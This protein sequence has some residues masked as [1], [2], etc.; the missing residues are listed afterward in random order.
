VGGG[1]RHRSFSEREH[2][3]AQVHAAKD[4]ADFAKFLI[5]KGNFTADHVLTLTKEK[6]TR[7][8]IK[9]AIGDTWLPSRVLEDDLVLIF[10]STH[11]SPSVS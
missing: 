3:A 2:S 5:E 10:A 7:D 9:D 11:G 6:A 8:N 4:A 1:N